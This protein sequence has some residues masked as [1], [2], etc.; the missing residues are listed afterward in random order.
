M[1]EFSDLYTLYHERVYWRCWA[2]TRH[3]ETAQD[4][5]QDVFVRV[6]KALPSYTEHGGMNAWIQK[7][8]ANTVR[9]WYRSKQQHT[10]ERTGALPEGFD[11]AIEE[12]QH[13]IAERDLLRLV[14]SRLDPIDATLLVARA[15]GE[16]R[17][18]EHLVELT[19]Q[20]AHM[21]Y[22]RV[23]IKARHIYHALTH[24]SA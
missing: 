16:M 11:K 4:L 5:T 9:D 3:V 10:E 18:A 8:T 12:P 2:V 22:K 6:W 7:I 20:A 21:R 14:L 13:W 15:N 17:D 24:E 19:R 23:A 1:I